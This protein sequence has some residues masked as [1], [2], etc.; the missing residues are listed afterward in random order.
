MFAVIHLPNFLLQAA[1]RLE[2]EL[3]VKPVVLV[4]ATE[5]TPKVVALSKCAAETGI[6]EGLSPVQAMARCAEVQVRQRSREQE[7]RVTETVLQCAQAFSPYVELTGPGVFTLDLR[8]LAELAGATAEQLTR[9]S[10]R[11][12]V[13]LKGLNLHPQIGL[14]STPNLARHAA[15][16]TQTVQI[17][18]DPGAFLSSLP[19]A[20]LD[21]SPA[22]LAVLQ[23]WGIATVG[24][25]LALDRLAVTER[26]G[27]EALDLF[28][29]ASVTALRPL[30]LAWPKERFEEAFDF[31]QP[32]ETLEPLLF[33]LRRLS[34]QLC[35]RLECAG[36]VAQ[37]MS[38]RLPQESGDAH[39]R[40]LRLPEPSRLPEVLFRML[41]T[42]LETVRTETGIVGIWLEIS[43]GQPVERQFS[44]FETVV[45]DPGRLQETLARLSALLGPDRVGTPVRIPGHRRDAFRMV[46]PDFENVSAKSAQESQPTDRVPWRQLRP[47]HPAAVKVGPGTN[48]PVD[49]RG[50]PGS[51]A[52]A[53]AAGPWRASGQW[54]EP[55]AW[56]HEDWEIA[57]ASGE[58]R[59]LTRTAEGWRVTGVL[60]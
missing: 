19:L 25:L 21:P 7:A 53:A 33:L 37:Q 13:A 29:A 59:R 38:L 17:V 23:R 54:W 30:R 42:H 12:S 16:W 47:G 32:V 46:A 11:L 41:H 55:E 36:L 27:L 39:E 31:E 1:L 60:D 26:L 48:R 9:W 40:V 58:V 24:E 6:T 3:W 28:A 51:G 45:R 18:D 14:G 10:T 56:W 15:R 22:V 52:V 50:T 8:T 20:A 44:L 49:V 5:A 2:P 34:D 57:T 35:H 4:D 43:P